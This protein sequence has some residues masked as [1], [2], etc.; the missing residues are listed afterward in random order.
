MMDHNTQ[1]T[2]TNGSSNSE[3]VKRIQSGKR[4]DNNT[5]S[6]DQ[7]YCNLKIHDTIE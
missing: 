1:Q 6:D 2:L 3:I 7:N 4:E 5:E